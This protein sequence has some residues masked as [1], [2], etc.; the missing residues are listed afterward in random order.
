MGQT[1]MSMKDTDQAFNELKKTLKDL[2]KKQI[3]DI[4]ESNLAGK[5]RERK[6]KPERK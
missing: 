6:F 2:S 1:N 3:M 5:Q 4:A